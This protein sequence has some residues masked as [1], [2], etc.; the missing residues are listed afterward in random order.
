MRILLACAAGFLLD[1]IFGD[2][3]RLYH[4]VR[5]I[6]HLITFIERS[7]RR[8]AGSSSK[9]LMAAGVILWLLVATVA[10]AA[11]ILLLGIA[12][13]THPLAGFVLEAFWCYQLLALKSLRQEGMKVYQKL[14]HDDLPAARTAV[15][16]IVGRDTALLNEEEVAKAAVETVA[17]NTSDGVIAPLFYMLIGGAPLAFFYK[18]VN[19]MDSM[20]GYKNEKYLYLGRA[21]AKMDDLLNFIPARISAL[22]MIAGT[23]LT[24]MNA[25]Q[26]I[27]VYR[28]DR[29]N[30]AS[31]NAA[32]TEAVCAGAL[33]IQLAGNAF[34]FGKL[35]EKPTIGDD[36]RP[37]EPEDIVR[38]C[39]LMYAAAFLMLAVGMAVR[40]LL[41][42]I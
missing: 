39:R 8:V 41:I 32:Q 10:T 36:G 31:P 5:L 11:A 20:V 42:S 37:V 28:R 40:F 3:P 34:Y 2:P 13:R 7:L 29:K 27:A 14:K 16:M 4:P 19:T 26:A 25:R 33:D 1:I 38:T 18:A 35:Y 24:G 21:A 23:F 12:G 15:S 6:G 17:E 30:H 9:G 22:L